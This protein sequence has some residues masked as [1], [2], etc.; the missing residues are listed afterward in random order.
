VTACEFCGNDDGVYRTCL[1]CLGSDPADIAM[2]LA[3]VL[4]GTSDD[5]H[6]IAK[7][8]REAM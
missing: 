6:D 4:G 5:W 8:M 7:A 2:A 3:I 1:D